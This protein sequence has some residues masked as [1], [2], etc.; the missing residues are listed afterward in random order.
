MQHSYLLLLLALTAQALHLTPAHQTQEV[1][2][3]Y[4]QSEFADLTA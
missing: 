4:F 2:K 1:D 3:L